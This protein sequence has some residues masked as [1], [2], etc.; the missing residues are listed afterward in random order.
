[1]ESLIKKITTITSYAIVLVIGILCIVANSAD[2]LDAFE[3]ISITMGV[4]FIVVASLGLLVDL[5]LGF[6]KKGN[7]LT[8]STLS[9]GVLLALGIFFVSDKTIGGNMIYYF[10]NY[11][12]YVVLVIGV[13]LA[14][15]ACF[16]LV[17][18][19]MNKNVKKSAVIAASVIK[20]VLA[21]LAII[22]G[23]LAMGDNAL[24]NNKFLIFGI[25][26]I[27]YAIAGCALALFAPRY[28]F[29]AIVK[30]NE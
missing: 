5:I 24:G 3:A 1:M 17:F 16:T 27:V 7:F 14:V 22:L 19:F 25:V 23:A 15:D 8:A 30:E 9:N 11:V 20:L 12:P 21:A 28:T 4:T 18:G 2:N 6:L 29:V 10:V 26:L 13:L